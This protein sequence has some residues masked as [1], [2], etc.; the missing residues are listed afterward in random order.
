MIH[1]KTY[2]PTDKMVALIAD[3]FE[4]IQVM[5]RFGIPMGVGDKTVG[6]VCAEHGVDCETFLQVVE[7]TLSAGSRS[8]DPSTLDLAA[9][10]TY[11]RQSHIYFLEYFLP[12]IRRK[13]LDSITLRTTD[14]SFLILRFFD[15]YT[16]EVRTH[17]LS[18]EQSVFCYVESLIAGGEPDS[19]RTAT[20]SRHHEE[21][22][23]KLRE[24]KRLII[25]YCPPGA[26]VNP[27]NAALYDI[28]RCEHE[29][30]IHCLVEDRMFVPALE[31]IEARRLG[32]G[33]GAAL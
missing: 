9:L 33:K 18:E 2:Q 11:L 1:S 6:E 24:L 21:V 25:Q 31:A 8:G 12:S 10:L 28:Y 3:N 14:V 27:L 7:F 30:E 20:Y 13:L 23:T 19:R 5:S 4:L 26:D 17:M 29:L 16:G 22:A 32:A 15:D